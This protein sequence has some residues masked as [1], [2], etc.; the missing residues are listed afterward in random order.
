M[1]KDI[2]IKIIGTRPGEK[3][4]EEI[5]TDEEH[6]ESTKHEKIFVAK[7]QD[8]DMDQLER[9]LGL[10]EEII[11][12]S[13]PPEVVRQALKALVPTYQPPQE[14]VEVPGFADAAAARE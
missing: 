7:L 13:P 3:L 8:V 1:G 12:Q 10:L 14:P 9:Q 11:K 4:Y 2:E 5:L 6:T